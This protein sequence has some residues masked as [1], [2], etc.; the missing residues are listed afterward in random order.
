MDFM[1]SL[2]FWAI[3]RGLQC[4]RA[5]G[6]EEIEIE[7]DSKEAIRLIKEGHSPPFFPQEIGGGQKGAD[8]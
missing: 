5:L 6:L 7:S 8:D 3:Y 4:I 1:G 2:E